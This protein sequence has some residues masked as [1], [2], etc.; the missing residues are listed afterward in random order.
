MRLLSSIT[1]ALQGMDHLPDLRN[2]IAAQQLTPLESTNA[3]CRLIT[4]LLDVVFEA[5]DVASDPT[6]TRLLVAL[7][8]FMQGKEYAGQERA[9]GAY[10]FC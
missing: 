7:F 2:K 9:W 10:W 4:G 6:M 1:F 8:N 3:Y 5:A